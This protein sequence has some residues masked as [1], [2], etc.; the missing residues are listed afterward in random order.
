ME[1]VLQTTNNSLKL[2]LNPKVFCKVCI[3]AD[4]WRTSNSFLCYNVLPSQ[5][6]IQNIVQSHL[7]KM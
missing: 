3:I 4:I 1:P 2:L 6:E 7:V 5:F